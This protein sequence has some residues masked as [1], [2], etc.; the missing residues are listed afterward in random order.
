MFGFCWHHCKEM[1]THSS[2]AK[3]E[4]NFLTSWDENSFALHSGI[5]LIVIM[6]FE[7]P[8]RFKIPRMFIEWTKPFP[9]TTTGKIRRD[10]LQKEVLSQL[11]SLHSNLWIYQDHSAQHCPHPPSLQ[12]Q[13]AVE[14][15]HG[16]VEIFCWYSTT[17]YST[18]HFVGIQPHNIKQ[19]VCYQ[20]VGQQVI[21]H[22]CAKIQAHP[23]NE[24]LF[25]D[26]SI[27]NKYVYNVKNSAKMGYL[28]HL[29]KKIKLAISYSSM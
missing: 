20:N 22:L 5:M 1:L 29:K 28:A 3:D 15:R 25:V 24:N 8:F 18:T 11:Q 9:L 26:P 7:S 23:N 6:C 27:P 19:H 4:Q 17:Q 14:F 12:E 10:Q 13:A 16:R 21:H 2:R